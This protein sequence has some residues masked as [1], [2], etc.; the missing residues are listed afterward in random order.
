MTHRDKELRLIRFANRAQ[1][2]AT[3]LRLPVALV[4]C[5]LVYTLILELVDGTLSAL[6]NDDPEIVV[7]HFRG[8]L[9]GLRRREDDR[10]REEETDE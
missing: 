9:R 5:G 7:R 2:L 6:G 3:K 4:A 10:S 1:F 8:E